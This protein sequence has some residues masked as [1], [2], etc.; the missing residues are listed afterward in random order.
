MVHLLRPLSRLQPKN[1]YH[2]HRP[3]CN[4]AECRQATTQADQRRAEIAAILR[5]LDEAEQM[6]REAG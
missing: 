4:C 1:D 2:I 5:R 6:T 3:P